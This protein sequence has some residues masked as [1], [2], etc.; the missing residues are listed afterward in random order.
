MGIACSAFAQQGD[1]TKVVAHLSGN[2]AVTN[3]GIS[4]IPNFSLEQPAAIFNM[5]LEK[6]RF[7]FDPDSKDFIWNLTLNYSFGKRPIVSTTLP[8]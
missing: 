4:L 6:G 8:R 2:A 7:S 5:S 3:N 1:S